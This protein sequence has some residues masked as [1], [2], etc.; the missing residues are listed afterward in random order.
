MH[1]Y[2]DDAQRRDIRIAQCITDAKGNRSRPP[3]KQDD[4][5]AY[6]HVVDRRPTAWSSAAPSCTSRGA[7][8]GHELMVMP[9]K[10]MK[11]G[12]EDYAIAA[13]CR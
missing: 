1:E 6:V 3:G 9:T 10:A 4:P 8:L 12:E 13:R 7:S 5:D 2:V 11:P